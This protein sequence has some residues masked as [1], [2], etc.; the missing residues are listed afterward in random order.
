MYVEE[1][2]ALTQSTKRKDMM[3]LSL[4]PKKLFQKTSL[5]LSYFSF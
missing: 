1:V 2:E 4:P 5:G 3:K